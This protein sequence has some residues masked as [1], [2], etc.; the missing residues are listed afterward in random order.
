MMPVV[1]ASTAAPPL[2]E[3]LQLLQPSSPGLLHAVCVPETASRATWHPCI[4]AVQASPW[5]PLCLQAGIIG[6]RLQPCL[7]VWDARMPRFPTHRLAKLTSTWRLP[8]LHVWQALVPRARALRDRVH[9]VHTR[10]QLHACLL[11]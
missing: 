1:L 3:R 5:L 8:S 9:P 11:L 4:V 6:M 2:C 7:P 10:V